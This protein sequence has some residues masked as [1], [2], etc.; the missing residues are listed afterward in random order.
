ASLA[1]APKE[2]SFEIKNYWSKPW[3]TLTLLADSRLSR[4]IPTFVEGS[5]IAGSVKLNLRSPDPIKSI[6]IFV[7]GDLIVSGD[8]D[9]RLHFFR[10][11]K[12]LWTPAMG[13][14]RA[15]RRTSSDDCQ[16]EDKLRGEYDW[17]FSIQLPDRLPPSPDEERL[18]RLPHT[19]AERFSRS[20]IEYYFELRIN[21]GKLRADD[22]MVTPFGFF[23]MQYP[24]RP[25]RLRQLA[26]QSNIDVPGPYSDPS[27]WLAL[28]PVQIQGKIFGER[29]VNAKCTVRWWTL[30]CYTRGT[31][32]PCA[33]TIETD[34]SQAAD[35]L[36]SIKSSALYLQRCVR[37]SFAYTSNDISPSGQATWWPSPDAALRQNSSQRHIMGEIHLRKDLQPSTA[38]KEFQVE[39]CLF[40]RRGW[41]LFNPSLTMLIS[42]LL[43]CSLPLL[44]PSVPKVQTL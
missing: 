2:Y 14:P 27:G 24:S 25:S 40:L 31:S 12:F 39:V 23:S 1:Q 33:M 32:I 29:A 9:E 42:T 35:V 20:R 43:F 6:A 11:R 17:P 18:F 19:F 10:M 41:S 7:R 34:D 15:P 8:P 44:W 30:L 37:C 3:A 28:D 38:I 22:R 4:T 16:W 26:Y 5:Q 21:R 13:D 36:A